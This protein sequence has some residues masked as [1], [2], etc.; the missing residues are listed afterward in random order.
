M[1]QPVSNEFTDFVAGKLDLVEEELARQAGA[2]TPFVTEAANHIISAGGKRFRPLLV[3]ICSQLG[4]RVSDED[5]VRAAVV[6]ELTHVASLYHDDVMDEATLRRGAE[7]ANQRW[8]NSVAI[9]VGDFLFA[10]ASETVSRLG[11][12]Y[13]RLQAQTFAR[14]VQGQIAETRGSLAGEDPLQHYLDVVADKTGSL[15][16]AAAVFG[17]MVSGQSPETLAV[18]RRF[19]EEIGIVFQLADDLLDITSTRTGKTPG[20]DLREG[21]ATLPVLL[22]RA[23][24]D[25]ADQPVKDL[26]DA[27]LSSDEA[28][29][30]AL[31]ALRSSHVMDEA[32][33]DIRARADRARAELAALPEGQ[34]RLALAELCDEVVGRSS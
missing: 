27:D 33:V 2:D 26:L 11:T 25:P 12:E 18:L 10:R 16:A 13:V 14:L 7:S 28:L 15:I 23:S 8:G 34:A 6:M 29:A 24:T 19:G 9:M 32:R 31:S 30:Q 21:V 1:S 3:V 4:G 20:I 22:L 5:L 17:G